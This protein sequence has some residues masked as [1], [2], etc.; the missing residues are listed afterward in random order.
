MVDTDMVWLRLVGSLKAQVSFA[1]EPYKRDDILQQTSIYDLS[2]L[3]AF[4][5]WRLQLVG[6]LKNIGLFCKRALQ[7]RRYSAKETP[8]LYLQ[9]L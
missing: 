1:K 6:S 8:Y 9:P 2:L 5:M 4:I 3:P 7:K